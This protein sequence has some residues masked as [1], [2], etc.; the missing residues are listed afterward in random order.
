M[1]C[2]SGKHIIVGRTSRTTMKGIQCLH[3]A[4]PSYPVI[5]IDYDDIINHPL[6]TQHNNTTALP[7]HLKS[8]CSMGGDNHILL[9]GTPYASI[10]QQLIQ[11][12]R[13][14]LILR[15]L[16]SDLRTPKDSDSN[17]SSDNDYIFT[18]LPDEVSAANVLYINDTIIRRTNKEF[19]L[20]EAI[21]RTGQFSG[22]GSQFSGS[23]TSA[24]TTQIQVEA[25]ELA[26]VDGALTCCSLLLKY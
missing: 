9:G 13:P 19:P 5:I 15:P 17:S 12:P 1:H 11:R 20:S 6:Y 21:F 24:T 10:I 3:C 22:S 16:K 7:L 8:M 2:K 4:F 14:N 26:K 18:H 23:G 25:S